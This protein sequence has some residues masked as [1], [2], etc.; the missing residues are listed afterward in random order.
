MR[1]NA[2]KQEMVELRAQFSKA[3]FLSVNIFDSVIKM[4]DKFKQHKVCAEFLDGSKKEVTYYWKDKETGILCKARLDIVHPKLGVMDV[5]S[6]SESALRQ[7]F[8]RACVKYNYDLQAGHYWKGA[9]VT[10]GKDLPF[11]FGVIEK[12][13]PHGIVVHKADFGL[14]ECGLDIQAYLLQKLDDFL[15]ARIPFSY[16]EKIVTLGLPVWGMDLDSRLE[17]EWL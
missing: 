12:A 7:S 4:G 13:E 15:N 9:A 8:M 5:K 3:E 1:T 11:H 10:L 16:P 6:T 2:G 17:K 14:I